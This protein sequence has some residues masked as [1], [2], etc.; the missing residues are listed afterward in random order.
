[1]VSV[2]RVLDTVAFGIGNFGEGFFEAW[3]SYVGPCKQTD[4]IQILLSLAV[5]VPPGLT[6]DA[7]GM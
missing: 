6:G 4:L 1:M 2:K 7:G 5:V 3:L